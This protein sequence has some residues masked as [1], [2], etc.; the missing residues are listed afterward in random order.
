MR[1]P[2]PIIDV[3][4]HI[5]PWRTMRSDA[6]ERM[7]H[8]E[9]FSDIQKLAD[10]PAALI[11]FLDERGI[12]K[13][14]LINE[15]SP[16]VT[17]VDEAANDFAA[18][19]SNRF[20]DRILAF[21]GIDPRRLDGLERRLDGLLGDRRMRGIKIHPPH[22]HL[23]ANAYRDG[24]GMPGLAVVYEKCIEFQ[25]PVMVHTGT[26]I[27]P[28]AR[29]KYGNPLDLDDL[30]TDFPELKIIL[31]HG[32]RPLWMK[33][34]LFILRRS[35]NVFLDISSVPPKR[36]LDY[37]PWIERLS[38]RALYGSDW[39]GPGVPDPLVNIEDFYSLPIKEEA[40][41]LILRENAV[42]L[43]RL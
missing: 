31:A 33:E 22:Q 36:L 9:D 28:R 16:E 43:F 10:D 5:P 42:K 3:H 19:L 30:I 40:K 18:G 23:H 27:F 14:F 26:S 13:V 24:G 32:G 35:Q 12:E 15:I 11:S 41:R 4:L 29:N 21:A 6:V 25:A 2:Y 7:S 8:R 37:F 39:P 20:P 34:A 1:P 17:G 38:D